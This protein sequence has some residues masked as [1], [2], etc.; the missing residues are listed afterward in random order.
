MTTINILVE[1]ITEATHTQYNSNL[2]RWWVFCHENQV[3]VYEASTRELLEFLTKQFD[4]GA[5]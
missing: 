5:S 4:E 3:D 1:S 2:R